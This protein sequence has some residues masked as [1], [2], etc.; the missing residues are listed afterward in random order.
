MQPR[1]L[2]LGQLRPGGDPLL[3][4]PRAAASGRGSTPF[5]RS[6]PRGLFACLEDTRVCMRKPRVTTNCHNAKVP[7]KMLC[8]ERGLRQP[9]K[10]DQFAPA[11]TIGAG[12]FSP[13]DVG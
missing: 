1:P 9:I 7:R 10:L 8:L 5:G 3:W 11:R 12:A 2:F 6:C 13:L 4:P